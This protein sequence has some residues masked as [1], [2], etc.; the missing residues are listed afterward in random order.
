MTAINVFIRH[1]AAHVLTDGA[2]Y[3][4][5]G[6]VTSVQQKPMIL[7]PLN[8]VLAGRGQAFVMPILAAHINEVFDSFDATI[9]GLPDAFRH[10]I[11]HLREHEPFRRYADDPYELFVAGFSEAQGRPE[12]HVMFNHGQHGLP[13]LTPILELDSAVTPCD[14]AFVEH[15]GREGF[16]A[17]ESFDPISDGLRLLR[18]QRAASWRGIGGGVVQAVAGFAQLTSVYADR[19]ETRILERW[20]A[21]DRQPTFEGASKP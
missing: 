7:A 2:F 18:A 15:L 14:P 19:I 13:I 8:M 5:D 20:P 3:Q 11:G 17:G 4:P 12:L 16:E 9:A 1:A 6:T 10:C 21:I